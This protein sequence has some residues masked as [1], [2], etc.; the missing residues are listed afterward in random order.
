MN[1]VFHDRLWRALWAFPHCART[2]KKHLEDARRRFYYRELSDISIVSTNCIGG[3]IYSA[4]G[5]QFQSPFVNVSLNRN[6]FVELC[7]QLP[8]YLAVE[9]RIVGKEKGVYIGT[10]QGDGL[11]PISIRFPHDLDPEV[12]CT[13]WERRKR[14]INM[15]KLVL[16]LDDQGLRDEGYRLFEGL[17]AFRKIL[18]TAG[19]PRCSSCFQLKEYAGQ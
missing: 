12:I 18:F 5:L 14:R 1:K 16:I 2:R 11:K 8:A 13:D 10:L 19:E 6:D 9:L 7:A 17:K 15:D 4:L 3:E